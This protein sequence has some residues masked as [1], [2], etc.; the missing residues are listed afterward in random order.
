MNSKLEFYLSLLDITPATKRIHRKAI[1]GFL[2]LLRERCR[3]APIEDD[4]DDYRYQLQI[5]RKKSISSVEYALSSVRRFFSWVKAN[6]ECS[7][8]ET[9]NTPPVQSPSKRRTRR[10]STLLS[11]KVYE[12]LALLSKH[13]GIEISAMLNTLITK[14]VAYRVKGRGNVERFCGELSPMKE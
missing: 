13:D 3:N 11:A 14:Y 6:P 10:V 12:N 9:M 8:I 1:L 7:S 4:Y 5:E 2:A